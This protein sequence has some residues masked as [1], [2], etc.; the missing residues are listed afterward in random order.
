[1]K[2]LLTVL[3]LAIGM[4]S[5]ANAQVSVHLNIGTQPIW[6][7][8][9]YDHVDYYYLPDIDAY[10]YVPQK[11]YI[12][13]RGNSWRRTTQLPAQ[14]RNVDLYSTHKV[15]I[16]GVD[17]PYLKNQEYQQQYGSFKGQHDQTPIR[18]A[19]EEKYYENRKH[20]QHS[21]WVKSHGNDNKGNKN[22]DNRDNHDDHGGPGKQ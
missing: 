7:P 17:R 1:M 22:R 4:T 10:Y 13:K 3:A 16:N 5:A 14:F 8:T 2:K 15:V 12:Y 21:E 9:G 11:Q 18:D 19:K 6:G 20:P